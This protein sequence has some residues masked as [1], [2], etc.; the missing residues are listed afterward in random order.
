MKLKEFKELI[1]L[2]DMN[3]LCHRCF[4]SNVEVYLDAGKIVCKECLTE[5]QNAKSR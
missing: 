5:I 1:T 3:G 4:R 2:R